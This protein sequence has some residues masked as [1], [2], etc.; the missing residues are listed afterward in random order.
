[1]LSQVL[2][3][4]Q[5]Q[6]ILDIATEAEQSYGEIAGKLRDPELAGA[7]DQLLRDKQRHVDLAQ[8]LLEIVE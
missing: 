6:R 4:E 2:L 7:V 3:Q 8:R 1:M 5:F